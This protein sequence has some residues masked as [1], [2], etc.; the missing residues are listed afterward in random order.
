[1]PISLTGMASGLDTESIVSQLMALEQNKV[2]A[3]QRRQVGVQQHK[4][5]LNAIKTKLDAVKTAARRA[6]RDRDVEGHADDHVVGPD[7][8]RRR[9]CSAAPAS[10]ATRSRSTK[11]ASSAQHG[12]TFTPNATAGS[13][14]ALLRRRPARHRRQQGHDRR[15][16]ERDRRRRRDRGQRQRGLAG[17]RRGGQGRPATSGSSSP[18]RKTGESSDFT[19]DTSALAGGSAGR[20]RAPTRA[21]APRPQRAVQARRRRRS[22]ARPSP[23]SSRT[24]SRA[25]G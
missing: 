20:G 6:E 5:D 23:T 7:E 16:R 10:A 11:L 24:R 14:D 22:R 12:F 2:T 9:R 13:L 18:S 15:R 3:V 21:P 8:G 4:D 25:C 1:M 17:L 19:V